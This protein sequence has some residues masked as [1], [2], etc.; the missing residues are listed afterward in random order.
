MK[1]IKFIPVALAVLS[2]AS[3]SEND[4]FDGAKKQYTGKAIEVTVENGA[5]TRAGISE[6]EGATSFVFTPGDQFKLYGTTERLTNLYEIGEVTE[7]SS[8]FDKTTYAAYLQGNDNLG[9][10]LAYALFPDK[11]ENFFNS[12]YFTQFEMDL[13]AEYDYNNT[14]ASAE[15]PVYYGTFPMWGQANEDHSKVEFKFAT[16]FIRFE[17]SGLSAASAAKL[18]ITA[19][20]QL[21]GRFTADLFDAAGDPVPF[22]AL[23]GADDD[24][25]HGNQ[26][27]VAAATLSATPVENLSTVAEPEQE[28][29]VNLSNLA[30]NDSKVIYVAVPAESYGY[31]GARLYYPNEER[32][33]VILSGKARSLTRGQFVKVKKALSVTDQFYYPSDINQELFDNKDKTT[34]LNYKSDVVMTVDDGAGALGVGGN[35]ILMPKMGSDDIILNFIKADA[36]AIVPSAGTKTLF[37]QDL[38]AADPFT[39]K[40]TI[41]TKSINCPLQINLPQADVVLIGGDATNGQFGNIIVD[42]VKSLTFGDNATATTL[43][44]GTTVTMKATTANDGAQ[45]NV[46]GKAVVNK[47][48]FN[49]ENAKIAVGAVK[50]ASKNLYYVGGNAK[51]VIFAKNN[52][53]VVV[54][55]QGLINTL[56]SEFV[57]TTAVKAAGTVTTSGAANIS[58]VSEAKNF[59]FTSTWDGVSAV[60]SQEVGGVKQVYTAAQLAKFQGAVGAAVSIS[61]NTDVDLQNKFWAGID[62]G[63][64]NFTIVGTNNHKGAT[65]AGTRD[66]HEI[67]NL[68]LSGDATSGLVKTATDNTADWSTADASGLGFVNAAAIVKVTNLIITNAS[69][70]LPKYN[71]ASVTGNK[72]FA[73]SNIGALAGYATGADISGLTVTLAGDNFGYTVTNK[74][75]NIGGVIGNLATA[76]ASTITKTKVTATGKIN[77]YYNLGGFIGGVT[78]TAATVTINGADAAACSVSL[79]GFTVAYDNGKD[80]DKNVGRIGGYIGSAGVLTAAGVY[81]NGSITEAITIVAGAPT[82]T[83]WPTLTKNKIMQGTAP[84]FDYLEYQKKNDYIGYCGDV[85]T[86]GKITIGTVVR[87]TPLTAP[88]A[89]A[90]QAKALYWFE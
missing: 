8:E 43:A 68:N 35:T 3:C 11:P 49:N 69:C 56:K 89:A 74:A 21:N 47:I 51:E 76:T 4:M 60:V 34:S 67:K 39:G 16:A 20:K 79:G 83:V 88:A 23:E 6:N 36:T 78:A 27:W 48:Q 40:L 84:D 64:N 80:I 63:A 17:L 77:G 71:A 25:L 73:A 30:N 32:T 14:L 24:W 57:G 33:D 42:G 29:T 70:A 45:V 44:G 2:L 15:T 58:A 85:T 1:R 7:A 50:D 5:A 55:G 86:A 10:S 46:L 12:E 75:A 9:T 41:N 19:D 62:A 31:I 72:K 53:T 13:D 65:L 28:I 82:V 87:T 81:Y 26:A 54:Q 37:I 61:L 90:D 59:E 18:I 22:P 66:V 52:P 38:D